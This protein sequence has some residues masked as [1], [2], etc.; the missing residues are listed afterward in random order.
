MTT[1]NSQ[2]FLDHA[3]KLL[4]NN[5]IGNGFILS[6]FLKKSDPSKWQIS[7]LQTGLFDRVVMQWYVGAN[8]TKFFKHTISLDEFCTLIIADIDNIINLVDEA[9]ETYDAAVELTKTVPA[10]LKDSI[11]DVITA[12]GE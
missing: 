6:T 4:L 5:H 12:A 11:K 1:T 3:T 10:H 9:S 8:R 7:F 2:R